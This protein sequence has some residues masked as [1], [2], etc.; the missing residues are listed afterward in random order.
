MRIPSA[1]ASLVFLH[2]LVMTGVALVVALY[3]RVGGSAFGLYFDALVI[4][5]PTLVGISAAVFVLFGL[6]R[7]IWRY[8]S[9]PDL[10]QVVRAVTVAVLCFVLAMFLLTRA[11][12]LPRSLPPILWL[13]QMLLL[14]G[15]RF[16][17]RFM[18]DRR[19][20]WAE[21]VEGVP[22]I[23]VLLLG[24]G[25][26]A[27][28]FIRSLDQPGQSAYRVVGILDD[29]GRRIGH[30]VRGVP[31]LGGPDDLEQVVRTLERKG[32]RPQ[33]L[34][35][36]KGNA[37][38]KGAMLRSLLDRAEAQGLVMSRLPS[39]TEFK[40]ALGE[41]KGVEVRPIALE[42][43]LGRP[44]AVL[45][46]GAISGLIGG[47]RVIVT[48]AGGTIG[49]EL[50]RQ[51]ATLGPERLIL[52]DAGEFNLY[53]IEMEVR[54]K[55]PG[56]D[57]RAVI[58]DVRDRDR[59]MRLFQDERPALVFHAAALKHVPLVEANPCE[60]ALTNVIGTRNV[61]DAAR[62]AGCLA[63]VLIS[64]DKAIR[65]T[66]VMGAAKRFA[67][68]YCQA[69]DVLPPR[70]ATEQATRYMTVRF[71]NVLGSSGSVVPLFTR[72]LAQG[73]PLTVTHPDMRR[74]FMTVREA[75]E[76]VLQA[77]AHGAT[78]AEDRGKILVLDMGEPVKIADLARQ[79][80]RLAG[81][82]PGVDI[83]IAYTGLRPGEKLFEEILTA[84]EAPSRTEADGVFLASPRLIDYALINRAVGELEAAARAGDGE[85]VLSILGTVVPD[86]R[87]EAVLPSAA[88][89]A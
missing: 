47:R 4:A 64:T 5:L 40:S 8:A 65:P 72:Q 76:L 19:F 60:G 77:S 23:P 17:Y 82:R 87:A 73:G 13:V 42:D 22:R 36:T 57:T 48:G 61:A 1:R 85:R 30:A 38:L 26:A 71:G 9:I 33:R 18:K 24:V 74:Y 41:G 16:A 7:G 39:L 49:S 88:T 43:L 20:S 58:A 75:V 3:L 81:Y 52:L 79:M 55:F 14:G 86:F 83:E 56:L 32:E 28:L 29:K 45:D 31:V 44:Q 51:I 53:S 68:T 62:A 59:I 11:E 78:R 10:I 84:A 35:I 21:A 25:D 27:E 66:S 15:P 6:Y 12:L 54:E 89:Q 63:M 67:E 70:D 50:V 37:E 34:I 80:I 2:D 46:R 69:L